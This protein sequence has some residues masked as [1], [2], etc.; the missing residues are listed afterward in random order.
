MTLGKDQKP[1]PWRTPWRQRTTMIVVI[2]AL[3]IIVAGAI[4][5]ASLG[6]PLF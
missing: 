2:V 3:V 1:D 5:A 6:F 4:V